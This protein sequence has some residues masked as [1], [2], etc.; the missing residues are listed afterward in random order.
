M[1]DR[2]RVGQY[3]FALLLSEKGVLVAHGN[4]D[5]KRQIAV[6]AKIGGQRPADTLA[7]QQYAKNSAGTALR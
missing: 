5:K 7:G 3:G 2:I 1:V 6:A 4:P